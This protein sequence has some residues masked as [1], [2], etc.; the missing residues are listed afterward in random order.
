[1]L[2]AISMVGSGSQCTTGELFLFCE[3]GGEVESGDRLTDRRNV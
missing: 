2:S 3:G 1:M